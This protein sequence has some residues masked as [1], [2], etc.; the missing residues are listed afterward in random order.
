LYNKKPNLAVRTRR[1]VPNARRIAVLACS[2]VFMVV[3][4]MW[5]GVVFAQSCIPTST[6]PGSLDTCFGI[7]GRV[8]TTIN[9]DTNYALDMALQTDGKIV[10]AATG[11]YVLRYGIDGLLDSIFGSGGIAR[12]S[13]NKQFDGTL[14]ALTLQSDG[15][16]IV[17]GWAPLK[18]ITA[19]FAIARLNSNG[20]LDTS[21]GSA[22]KIVFGFQNNVSAVA[23]AVTIQANGYIVVAGDSNEAFALARLTPNGAFDPGFNGNGK[24]TVPQANTHPNGGALDVK[25]QRVLVSGVIQEKL[26]AVGLRPALGSVSTD[27]AVMRFNPNGALDATFGSGGK[28][29][30]DFW[31]FSDQAK[32]LA[33]DANNN[34]V[35]AGHTLTGSTTATLRFALVRY[36]ENG[37]LDTSFGDSGRVTA[38]VP[39]YRN[40]GFGHALAIQPDGRIVFSGFVETGANTDGDFAV[41]R[42]NSNGTV[43]TTFGSAGTGIVVTDFYGGNDHAW[44]GLVLQPDGRIVVGGQANYNQLGLARYMP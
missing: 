23:R 13:F 41:G 34:I 33:I 38:G 25:I 10:V 17:Y 4:S 35:V 8:L 1:L 19:G 39:G 20:S 21:F 11:F 29:F 5:S 40:T 6:A 18:G 30:T 42:L 3:V 16:I 14:E 32:A 37:Q 7:G 22:G 27:M 2:I 12:I 36:T 26:V 31:G 43:D 28:V 15:R 24:V 9:G 44:A